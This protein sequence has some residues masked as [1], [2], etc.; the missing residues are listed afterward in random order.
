VHA[1]AG[2]ARTF[3]IPALATCLW[4]FSIKKLLAQATHVLTVLY[5]RKVCCQQLKFVALIVC[6]F[7]VS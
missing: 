5:I 2:T 6:D 1:F 4:L 3:F 7:V